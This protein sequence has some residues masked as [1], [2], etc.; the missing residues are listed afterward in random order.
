MGAAAALAGLAV[1]SLFDFGLELPGLALPA[2]A[3][4]GLIL[5][6]D[7]AAASSPPTDTDPPLSPPRLRHL[8]SLLA[9]PPRLVGAMLPLM[10]AAL[11]LLARPASRQLLDD[12]AQLARRAAS[13]QVS[14]AELQRDVEE[15]LG[16]HPVDYQL[17][18]VMAYRLVREHHPLAITWLN[19]AL[20]AAPRDG[21][22]H[23]SA[24]RLLLRRG[25]ARQAALEYRL[26]LR[27]SHERHQAVL[28]EL[29]VVLGRA[30]LIVRAVEDTP[31]ALDDAAAMLERLGRAGV[32]RQVSGLAA[33]R[34]PDD[35]RAPAR[36][37]RLA[38]SPGE[39]LE[40]ARRRHAARDDEEGVLM[41]ARALLRTG[42]VAE[43]RGALERHQR[44]S[45]S[46]GSAELALV[47]A[48]SHARAGQMQD[49]RRVL[50]G[51]LQAL[52]VRLRARTLRTLAD[53]EEAHGNHAR[54]RAHRERADLLM[55]GR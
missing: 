44:A 45:R 46:D 32:A 13:G 52:D 11:L 36:R 8:S 35:A 24:A 7:P 2:A 33:V 1:Q 27:E 22:L 43:A 4:L 29:C 42:R 26:A 48:E 37:V 28:K 30:E 21:R 55:P 47:L 10:L 16:R 3:C 50:A 31:A 23:A 12:D 17:Y 25:H 19:R 34:F 5:A 18:A 20:W 14:L 38:V 41:L 15:A 6:R 39:A 9:V 49:A 51:P 40:W 53:L 54:A